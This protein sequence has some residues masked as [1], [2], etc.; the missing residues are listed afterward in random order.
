MTENQHELWDFVRPRTE[1][2]DSVW[3]V[4]EV[5]PFGLTAEL[6]PGY[7]FQSARRVTSSHD[8]FI[9]LESEEEDVEDELTV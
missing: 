4:V 9:S 2:E 5:T 6:R 7:L 8:F 3:R 1:S